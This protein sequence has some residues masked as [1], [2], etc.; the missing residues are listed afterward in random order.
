MVQTASGGG[1]GSSRA[2]VTC[3]PHTPSPPPPCLIS[4][5]YP[6]FKEVY[7]LL[8]L[9]AGMR[10]PGAAGGAGG[11]MGPLT[12]CHGG[13]IPHQPPEAPGGH[14]LP[15][16]LGRQSGPHLGQ[17]STQPAS[18]C[19][20]SPHAVGQMSVVLFTSLTLIK[21]GPKRALLGLLC[22]KNWPDQASMTR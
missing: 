3:V 19:S 13:E 16:R 12:W 21:C 20:H 6:L 2:P 11:G 1:C 5:I 18:C 17:G 14:P 4:H 9:P 22:F 15:A 8:R 7:F 10:G